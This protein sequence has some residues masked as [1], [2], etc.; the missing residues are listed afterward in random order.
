MAPALAIVVVTQLGAGLVLDAVTD[1]TMPTGRQL[2][3][4]I[5]LGVGLLLV[6]KPGPA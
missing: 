2:A 5:V 6:A 3:G 4:I 1:A